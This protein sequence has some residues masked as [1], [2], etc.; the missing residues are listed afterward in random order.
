MRPKY[1]FSKAGTNPHAAALK[2]PVTIRL[3]RSTVQYFKDL[4]GKLGMPYQSLINLYLRDCVTNR[5][6][7]DMR[8][9]PGGGTG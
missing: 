4:A 2:S 6:T 7:L 1:D 9:R 8:W 5:R 3:D